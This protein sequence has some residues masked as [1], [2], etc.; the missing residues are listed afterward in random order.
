LIPEVA[1]VDRKRQFPEFRLDADFP[2]RCEARVEDGS[3]IIDQLFRQFPEAA[4]VGGDIEDRMGVEEGA[5]KPTSLITASSRIGTSRI[6]GTPWR[7][8]MTVFPASASRMSSDSLVF[9]SYTFITS[10][11]SN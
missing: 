8:I 2:E 7:E 6:I 11:Y 9:A 1:R 10:T 5:K 3:R 4:G